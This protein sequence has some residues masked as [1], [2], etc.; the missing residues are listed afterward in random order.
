MTT[1]RS[2]YREYATL[3]TALVKW[4][5]LGALVGMLC[6]VSS[7]VFLHSL[8]WATRAQEKYSWLLFLLPA[9]GFGIGLVYHQ[10]GKPVEGGNNLLLERI[11]DAR[12]ATAIPFRL[13]PLVLFGTVVTHL[14][15]GSAGR[16]GTAVQMGGTFAN[17]LTRVFPL[18]RRDQRLLIMSGISGGFG[19]VFGTP[20]AGT[21]FGLEVLSI[22]RVGYEALL[23]CFVASCVGD[24]VCRAL[25]IHHAAYSVGIELPRLT[26]T[27]WGLIVLAGVL[28]AGAASLFS[29]L[30]EAVSRCVK[31]YISYPPLRPVLGGIAIIA[32]TFAVGS[33]DYLGL[34]LPLL[35]SAFSP[36]GVFLFAFALKLLFT[37]VTLGTG[38]KG[39]EVTPLFVIGATLGASFAALTGQPTGFFAALGFV[40]VFAGAANTPLACTLLGIELFGAPM[41]VP[42]AAACIISYLLSGHRGIYASQRVGVSKAGPIL[43]SRGTTLREAQEGRQRISSSRSRVSRRRTAVGRGENDAENPVG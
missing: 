6:G 14:F 19:A 37:A 25:G 22:G 43:V 4:V 34:S 17:L 2:H 24:I 35:Q 18:G 15:G 33:R 8:D 10:F 7:A 36:Q 1:F 32:L 5:F 31:R 27:L 3:L 9:A 29:E 23:P 40:A 39:G 16:E 26:L 12:T 28:F 30:T 41:G 42:F 11:H 21:V 20:L 13:A 38:F